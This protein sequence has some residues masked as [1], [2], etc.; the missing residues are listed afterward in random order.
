M[1][2]HVL[3]L[4]RSQGCLDLLVVCLETGPD[5]S[6]H[7]GHN[8]VFLWISVWFEFL[9]RTAA[10]KC[11]IAS[12]VTSQA[13]ARGWHQ[14]LVIVRQ[15]SAKVKAKGCTCFATAFMASLIGSKGPDQ[16]TPGFQSQCNHQRFQTS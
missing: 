15:K 8:R 13:P 7:G 12:K 16:F 14:I 9:C 6:G 5:P 10:C 11:A 1:D 3:Q 4:D 2:R